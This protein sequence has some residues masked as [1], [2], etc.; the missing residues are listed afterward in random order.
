MI[1]RLIWV[2]AAGILIGV[3]GA[4]ITTPEITPSG[5]W[6]LMVVT[7]LVTIICLIKN[8]DVK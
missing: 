4:I 2:Y 5:V 6:K 7:W 8:I 1:L 3:S